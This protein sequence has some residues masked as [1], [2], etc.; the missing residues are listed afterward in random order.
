MT[1]K[2][3]PVGR[4]S[5]YKKS[6]CKRVIAWGKEGK[7]PAYWC[8]QLGVGKS[9]LQ[10]WCEEHEEF[11]V[12]YEQGMNAQENWEH[13]MLDN[14]PSATQLAIAKWR[15]SAYHKVSEVVKQ[16]IKSDINAT[17]T[18]I[19]MDFGDRDDADTEES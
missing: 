15:T 8:G 3:N 9:S 11:R 12:A 10:R 18:E 19:S 14:D 4:P 17:V 2:K 13:E 6:Y 1:T 7:L 5:L 16:E